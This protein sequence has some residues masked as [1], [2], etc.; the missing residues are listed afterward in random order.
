MLHAWNELTW[1]AIAGFIVGTAYKLITMALLARK[2]KVVYPIMDAHFGARSV[3]H[4]LLP[5]GAR[6]MRL[7]PLFTVLSFAFHLCLLLTPL[8]A[9]GHAMLWRQSWSL[10][11]LSLPSW[12]TDVMTLTVLGI[13][14]FF[15]ARRVL[16]PEVRYV[17]AWR[18]FVVLLIVLAPFATG[19]VARQ[20]WF[21]YEVIIAA[22][23]V[24]GA[25]WL[26]AIPF[27][28]LSHMLWFVFSRAYMGSE[29]GA[30]RHARDW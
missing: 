16:L 27:T 23:V 14:V 21:S 9:A 7:H 1:V 12:L 3:G 17:S 24:S 10:P 15:V 18:D 4:W 20:H 29:F 8:L 19:F 13:G 22:H 26:L 25:I 2:D 28:R 30:V 11:W 6:S 5:L